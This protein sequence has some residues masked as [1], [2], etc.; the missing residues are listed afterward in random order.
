MMSYTIGI[1]G[2]R[3]SGKST[4]A[5]ALGYLL[6]ADIISTGRTREMIRALYTPETHPGLFKSV[7]SLDPSDACKY[8]S[9]QSEFLKPSI[10]SAIRQ[11][12]EREANLVV[13]G[14]HVYPGIYASENFDLQ[15]FLVA[16]AQKIV[17]RMHKDKIR[18]TSNIAVSTNLALQEYLKRE[19]EIHRIHI[20]DTQDIPDAS[21]R[22]M[23]LIPE[24]RI[25]TYFG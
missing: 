21:L 19:A 11:C 25:K 16:P 10:D 24:G 2:V 23:K 4:I 22:I 3:A 1:G 18:N 17:Y 5:R 15:V 20:I 13:E 9:E 12:K 7:T 14:S 6:R 8:L